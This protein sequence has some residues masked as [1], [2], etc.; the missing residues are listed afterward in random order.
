MGPDTP[1][2]SLPPHSLNDSAPK[3]A[4]SEPRLETL[5]SDLP[6]HTPLEI[7]VDGDRPLRVVHAQA[8]K[9]EALVYL[10]GMCGNPQGADPWLDLALE[11]GTLIVVRATEKCPDRPGYKWP[12]EVELIQERIDRALAI[13]KE[14][15]GGVLDTEAVTLIGYSQGANRAEKLAGR[16][17]RKYPRLVLGG[18]PS[19]PETERFT[20]VRAVA[21]LGGEHED[22]SHMQEGVL[23][24]K[25]R[26]INARFFLL[27]GGHHGDYGPQGRRIMTQVLDFLFM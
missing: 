2:G 11:R 14:Q 26:N 15:R 22:T 13:V 21:V 6:L 4:V 18:T 17:P 19:L 9:R 10:H 7:P 12:T 5:P 23:L 16:S 24:L 25:E 1:A 20:G 3:E 8:E 27:P